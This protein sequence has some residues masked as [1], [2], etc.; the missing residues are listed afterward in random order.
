MSKI[1]REDAD[2]DLI[3]AY[4]VEVIGTLAAGDIFQAAPTLGL[5]EGMPRIAVMVF[6]AAAA[7]ID[8]RRFGGRKENPSRNEVDAFIKSNVGLLRHERV[9]A[10][11]CR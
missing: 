8:C 9:V 7:S 6:A 11:G 4:E 5:A 2:T 1:F 10:F 3:P